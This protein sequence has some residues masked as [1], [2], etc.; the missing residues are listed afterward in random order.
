ME[1]QSVEA[2]LVDAIRQALEDDAWRGLQR[3]ALQARSG[4]DAAD[5][6]RLAPTPLAALKLVLRH[7]DDAVSRDGP[8]DKD[9]TPRDRLFEIMMRRYEA[10][11]PWRKA[12]QRLS[13][14]LP[15]PD[16]FAAIGLTLAIERSMAAMLDAAGISS[17]GLAGAARVRGLC[18]LHA[19]V[20]RTFLDDET[21][22]LAETMKA[23]DR[24]LKDIE[25]L[26]R[27]LDR[28]DP[29]P[30]TAAKEM[31]TPMLADK[32]AGPTQYS[33]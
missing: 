14:S 25:P 2:R 10:L 30:R 6:Q 15:P 4:L 9:E 26:A 5:L 27:L 17:Q 18:L 29:L 8:A 33:Q 23:L 20:L 22:D 28:F 31:S 21:V 19:D 1:S 3:D 16:P 13:R 11:V 7:I 32:A 12:L 24:R